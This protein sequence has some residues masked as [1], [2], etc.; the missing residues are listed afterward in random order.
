MIKKTVNVVKAL[1]ET[2]VTI[3]DQQYVEY[4][5]NPGYY[6]PLSKEHLPNGIGLPFTVDK[7][8]NWLEAGLIEIVDTVDFK[9]TAWWQVM[10]EQYRSVLED[11]KEQQ[12]LIEK[13]I[14]DI[15]NILNDP[16]SYFEE[17]EKELEAQKQAAINEVKDYIDNM[18]MT[19]EETNTADIETFV[20]KDNTDPIVFK[21][22]GVFFK[23]KDTTEYEQEDTSEKTV[24]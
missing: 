16:F 20:K 11:L 2:E 1:K 21:S 9:K 18:P 8:N 13:E 19:A 10:G 22:P 7:E 23:E 5:N 12:K 15:E 24:D 14:S 4:F 6:Y 3:K 17:I